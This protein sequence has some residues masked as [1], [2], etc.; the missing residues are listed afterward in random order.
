MSARTKRSAIDNAASAATLYSALPAEEAA[1]LK[2]LRGKKRDAARRRAHR[3]LKTARSA[4]RL[5]VFLQSHSNVVKQAVVKRLFY[6]ARE[7]YATRF[8]APEKPFHIT[9]QA[10][11]A[12]SQMLTRVITD[13]TAVAARFMRLNNRAKLQ[14]PWVKEAA[15]QCGFVPPT[16]MFSPKEL[17]H[18]SP[19]EYVNQA[20]IRHKQLTHH[21]ADKTKKEPTKKD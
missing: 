6:K 5:S 8:G 11:N 21:R 14:R 4:H 17:P 1:K 20:M 19:M 3:Q 9:K 10:R 15:I 2:C 13:T 7:D 16:K 18:L 12:I